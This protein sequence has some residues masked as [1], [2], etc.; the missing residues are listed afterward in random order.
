MDLCCFWKIIGDACFALNVIAEEKLNIDIP[1]SIVPI[2]G[3]KIQENQ[4]RKSILLD[5]SRRYIPEI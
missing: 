4:S 3:L 1:D 2:V 5:L